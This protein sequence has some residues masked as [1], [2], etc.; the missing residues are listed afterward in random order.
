MAS[1][2]DV[3]TRFE[4]VNN[5]NIDDL[6]YTIRTLLKRNDAEMV[7]LSNSGG[8]VL[9]VISG[10]LQEVGKI[11]WTVA[12]LSMIGHLLTKMHQMSDNRDQCLKL[13]QYM[14]DLAEHIN[15]LGRLLPEGDENIEKA[16]VIIV[17][18]SMLCA[19]QLQAKKLLRFLKSSLDSKNL[20][21]LRSEISDLYPKLQL[22]SAIATLQQLPESLRQPDYPAH[23][24]LTTFYT[25][26]LQILLFIIVGIEERER[27]VEDML[28][29]DPK[30]VSF[31]AVV[32][33]G[34]GGIGKTYLATAV[35]SNLILTGYNYTRVVM[36]MDHQK[37]DIKEMQQQILND[38]FPN[39]MSVREKKNLRNTEDGKE[40]LQRP[41]KEANRPV[42]LLIENALQA[43]D[44]KALLPEDMENF[45]K[46]IRL[47]VTTRNLNATNMFKRKFRHG[48]RA[49]P[50][51]NSDAKKILCSET[52]NLIHIKDDVDRILEI[53]NGVPLVLN[54]VGVHLENQGYR[55]DKCSQILNALEEGKVIKEKNL[56]ACMVDFVFDGFEDFTQEAFLDICCFFNGINRIRVESA[57]GSLALKALQ[58]AALITIKLVPEYYAPMQEN[59][60]IVVVHDV[61][62]A[63]GKNMAGST[64]IRD[65]KSFETAVAKKLGQNIRVRA[66]SKVAFPELRY[67][68]L[69]RNIRFVPFKLKALPKLAVY[70]GPLVKAGVSI[71]KLPESLLH[72]S[73]FQSN[74]NC[75]NWEE[76]KPKHVATNSSLQEL[77][78][79]SFSMKMLPE[80]LEG[81]KA[82]RTLRLDDWHEMEEVPEIMCGL[83]WL[84]TLSLV[85]CGLKVLP[86]SFGDLLSLRHLALEGCDRLE[87][88][89]S[90]LGKLKALRYLNLKGCTSLKKL[91]ST[92]GELRALQGLNLRKCSSLEVVPG[93]E[94]LVGLKYLNVQHCGKLRGDFT[95]THKDL[96]LK[97]TESED[98]GEE[99]LL[100]KIRRMGK[101]QRQRQFTGSEKS[102]Y[103]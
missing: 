35:Y 70:L 24:G 44:L 52:E 20:S 53:C 12:G 81:F 10:I 33:Y 25:F 21:S 43:D 60:E 56:S 37:N 41:F 17:K 93:Y 72:I 100:N 5:A 68:Y 34:F 31:R 85:K 64:R 92:F 90:T 51:P 14:L 57:V 42:F 54:I 49:E 45:G 102:R 86:L 8:G 65:I 66:R 36:S 80:G 6:I 30:D 76:S 89:P 71:Y 78:L 69:N 16:L 40:F 84:T 101:T 50:L 79:S 99:E 15:N 28:R 26:F 96:Q 9:S 73:T 22:T 18:G 62:Q 74:G 13:L 3:K 23:E 27:Q 103:S 97:D 59:E 87:E 1:L 95:N 7:D 63:Q 88:L 2:K 48:Y 55:A 19:K 67:V 58:D 77:K 29:M 91:P 98:E 82:L 11:H 47:L 39:Y 83:H 4:A 32:I 61:I 94:R 46:H 75:R 38:V